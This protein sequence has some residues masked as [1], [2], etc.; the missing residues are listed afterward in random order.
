MMGFLMVSDAQSSGYDA[1]SAFAFERLEEITSRMEELS[2]R[3]SERAKE[4][5][6]DVMTLR[7]DPQIKA[8]WNRLC[9]LHMRATVICDEYTDKSKPGLC[10]M[11]E[12]PQA[13]VEVLHLAEEET[14]CGRF[15]RRKAEMEA[16]EKI[17]R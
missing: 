8:L 12:R 7:N 4:L 9:I 6:A 1:P 10:A 15:M 14:C 2:T 13:C 17:S 16:M 11:V 3:I 5:D